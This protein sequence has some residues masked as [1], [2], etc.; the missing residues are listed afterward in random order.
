MAAKIMI[1][2]ADDTDE[3]H[4]VQCLGHKLCVA[5]ASS[6]SFKYKIADALGPE[7]C[8]ALH[9]LHAFSGCDMMSSFAG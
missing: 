4:A 3:L 9:F 7:K 2:I 1:C 8:K 5:L 6:K